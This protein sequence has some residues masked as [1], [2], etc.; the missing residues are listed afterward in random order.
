MFRHVLQKRGPKD[1]L[2]INR[3]TQKKDSV[4]LH[5]IKVGKMYLFTK[6]LSNQKD[7]GHFLKI[8]KWNSTLKEIKTEN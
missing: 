3:S 2:E 7:S 5:P 8:K 1:R 4:S 6:H